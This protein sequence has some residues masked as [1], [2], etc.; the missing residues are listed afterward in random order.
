M[1]KKYIVVFAIAGFTACKPD[2]P[3]VE[4]DRPLK[5]N[6]IYILADDLGYGDLSCYGQQKFSTPQIDKMAVEGMKFTQHYSGSTVCAP[7]RSSLLTGLHTGHTPIR[8]NKEVQPE[9]QWPLSDTIVTL[10]KLLKKAGYVNG[11]YGK[12][13]LGYPGS[14][15][16]PN[17]QGFDEFF[18]YNCQRIAHHYY[19]YYIWHNQEKVYLKG[20]EGTATNDYAPEVIHQKALEFIEN[21]KDTPF[22]LFYASLIPH[23]ELLAPEEYM[24]PF[25]G[26]FLPEN[27]YK[28]V[29]SGEKFRLGPYGS[30]NECHAA[31]AAMVTVL[32]TQVGDLIRKVRELGIENN[33]II[34]F[35]SDNG[36]A[37]EGGANPEYFNSSGPLK[38][39][40]RDLY[41][42]GIRVPMVAW[43]PGQIQPG[44]VS[45]HISSF[46]D[47]LPTF[48]ELAGIDTPS[49]LDGISFLPSLLG[50]EGQKQHEHLYWEFH[51]MGG[52]IALRMGNW[53]A[54][55]YNVNTANPRPTELYDLSK[56]I[57]E[58]IDL[59]TEYPEIVIRMED[60]MKSSRIPSSVFTFASETIIQ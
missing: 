4:N 3:V 8:G 53:K 34:I 7:S 55:K 14:E 51:E 29:D 30:Q 45:D 42:G 5:P 47:V 18:G 56:D 52:R 39:L 27:K 49:G 26:K 41:E 46:W 23:A 1:I 22:F 58:N 15:G 57:G 24:A 13:G 35:T 40:K 21:N 50:K 11:L 16:D 31:F 6:I 44:S 17:K 60:I 33:T 37:K 54:V 38:G 9:G 10:P 59:A 48:T 25:R 12:W 2:K 28:G 43:W 20:N 32:D 19:P 36:A